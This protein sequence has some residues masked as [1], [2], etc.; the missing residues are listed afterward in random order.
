MHKNFAYIYDEFTKGVDYNSWYKFLRR[1]IKKKGKVLDIGC[2]TGTMTAMFYKDG[3]D[4][5]GIDISKEMVEIASNKCSEIKYSILDIQKEYLKE[6]FDYIICNFDTV[7]YLESIE[8]FINHCSIM[9][10]KGAYLIFDIITEGIFDEIFENNLFVDEEDNYTAIWYYEKL[11][12]NKH[13]IDISIFM[14]KENDLYEK[15]TES[16]NKYI[17]EMENI[18][19]ILNNNGYILYDTAKNSKYGESRI[20]LIAKKE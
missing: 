7:N 14:K 4:I 8:K 12:K 15:Y 20:F 13:H 3:F 2:G 17:Y 9:Q 1:Y 6:N 11:K 16:H 18:I 5:I 19:E 10:N